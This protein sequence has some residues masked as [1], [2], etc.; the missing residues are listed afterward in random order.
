MFIHLC[1]QRYVSLEITINK[2]RRKIHCHIKGIT[3]NVKNQIYKKKRNSSKKV[4]QILS[5][6]NVI[7]DILFVFLS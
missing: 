4:N 7:Q 3:T 5:M 2:T 6:K 1:F